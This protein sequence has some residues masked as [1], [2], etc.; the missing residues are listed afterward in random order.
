MTPELQPGLRLRL[1][2]ARRRLMFLALR[3]LM[4]LV[5]FERARVLGLLLGELQFRLAWVTRRR[6]EHD[7]ALLLGREPGDAGVHAQLRQAYHLNTA[8]VFEV[9]AMFH[10]RLDDAVI[11]ARCRAQGLEHLQ[12]ALAGGRGAI[13]LGSH[14][15]NG[16][17]LA[18]QLARSGIPV[19]V[20]YRQARMMSADLFEQGFALYGIE[21]ILANEGL[22]AYGRMLGA[23]K[24]NRVVF[25]MMD[26]G[27]KRAEDGVPMRFLG[28]D[29]PMPAGPAQLARH[30]R[31]PVLPVATV[32]ADPVWSFEI[33]EAVQR[34]PGAPLEADTEQLLRITEQQVL[35]YPH[36][37][38][39]HH[40]RWRHFPLAAPS[41]D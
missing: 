9:L 30:A 31:A 10:R 2:R 17:L 35:R 7:L 39:W 11:A 34:V 26:Q 15:G 5:G 6:C 12:A 28:K 20:V 41:R 25:L 14:S 36:L 29:M 37:W 40:R 8:A 16:V 4:R 27:V 21:G 18:L 33:G 19:S 1:R 22:K 3:G 38:S 13:L 24:K 32:A 23:L